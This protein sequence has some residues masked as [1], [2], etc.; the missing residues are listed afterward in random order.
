MPLA[1]RPTFPVQ[2]QSSPDQRFC[3]AF[4]RQSTWHL[5]FIAYIE[6]LNIAS[7]TLKKPYADH[8][9]PRRGEAECMES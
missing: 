4:A 7:G 8:W 1:L 6:K 2:L 3:I 9:Q 5:L